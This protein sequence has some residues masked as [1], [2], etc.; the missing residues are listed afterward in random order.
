MWALAGCASAGTRATGAWCAC[1]L[2]RVISLSE[3]RPAPSEHGRRLI[4][5]LKSSFCKG[6]FTYCAIRM[7]THKRITQALNP[8]PTPSASPLVTPRRA[9]TRVPSSI[10]IDIPGTL[11]LFFVGT[12]DKRGG[13]KA[14]HAWHN[15]FPRPPVTPAHL[16]HESHVELLRLLKS[17]T[18]VNLV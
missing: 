18:L 10:D 6:A 1:G 16:T 5:R 14:A 2:M 8:V 11:R 3:T 17:H 12:R 9:V 4:R 13:A 7:I 15:G